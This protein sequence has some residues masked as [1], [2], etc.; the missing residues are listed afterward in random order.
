MRPKQGVSTSVGGFIVKFTRASKT[1]LIEIVLTKRKKLVSWFH[2][3]SKK[4][5]PIRIPD[6]DTLK[7]VIKSK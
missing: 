7:K 3:K 4:K 5:R 6:D 2:V 1:A